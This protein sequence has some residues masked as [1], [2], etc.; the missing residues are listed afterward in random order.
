MPFL[1]GQAL[2]AD[3]QDAF[4][5]PVIS[6]DSASLFEHCA[7]ALEQSLSVGAHG[8]PLIGTGDWN[9]GMNRV[10][11]MGRGESVWLG[12]L[13][14]ATLVAFAPLARARDQPARETAVARARGGASAVTGAGGLG[15]R[16]VPARLFR[17]WDAARIGRQCRMSDRFHRA[18][19]ERHL[20]RRRPDPR[21]ECDVRRGQAS[22][23]TRHGAGAAVHAALRSQPARPRLYQ[24][25]SAR[26]FAKTAVSTHTRPPGR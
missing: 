22:R 23:S 19:L 21:L 6:D 3:E 18:I 20:G 4:F 1:E 26:E 10:G 5:Q 25:L 13:L 7:R 9:D 2:R 8:L 15:R 12:W 24:G 11:E 17:R 14:H 16:M